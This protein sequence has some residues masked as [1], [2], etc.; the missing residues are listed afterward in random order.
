VNLL[1]NLNNKNIID[2]KLFFNYSNLIKLIFS[3]FYSFILIFLIPVDGSILDRAN[4]LEYAGTSE[5]IILRNISSGLLP[6]IVNEPI[7]L[8]INIFFNQFVQPEV[9]VRII[10]FFASFVSCIL[11]LKSNSK[12][13]L[14]LFIILLFPNV[15][16]KYIIHLRQGLAVSFFLLGWFS[17]KKNTRLILYFISPLIHSS[18]FIV[19]VLYILSK[20]VQ[21]IKISNELSFILVVIFGLITSFMI[22]NVSIFLGARQGEEYNFNIIQVS[23]IGFLF[24]TLIYIIFSLQGKS[25]IKNHHFELS[26]LIFYL[27]T[28]FF[29]DVTGRIF[30]SVVILILLAGI[31]LTKWRKL[32][33]LYA[34]TAFVS[35]SWILNY[36]KSWFGWG[37]DF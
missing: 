29:L 6:F 5:V 22:S 3:L 7:W 34:V 2:S 19:L 4:Y 24:W 28:Y 9:T 26:I 31:D 13:L 30:E 36:N 35:I 37:L 17:S 10:I 18:F 32:A 23:G 11:I 25:F 21:N 20:I 15:L 12:H 1:I 8:L 14:I 33:F 27:S 16:I